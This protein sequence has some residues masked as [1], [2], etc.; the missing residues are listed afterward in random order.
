MQMLTAKILQYS[1]GKSDKY[2]QIAKYDTLFS[3]VQL[4]GGNWWNNYNYLPTLFW[5]VNYSV[6]LSHRVCP[7]RKLIKK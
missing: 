7:W 2:V 6:R 5:I 3:S 1:N 4:I